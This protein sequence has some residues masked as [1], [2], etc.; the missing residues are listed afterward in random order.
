MSSRRSSTRSTRRS[1]LY[2]AG[3]DDAYDI[4]IADELQQEEDGQQL[5]L[6][7]ESEPKMESHTVDLTLTDSADEEEEN[8][9][10]KRELAADVGDMS[11]ERVKKRLLP[12]LT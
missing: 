9:P 10:K 2:E 6:E 5:E 1:I 12:H 3:P 4:C 11:T 7:S 8:S